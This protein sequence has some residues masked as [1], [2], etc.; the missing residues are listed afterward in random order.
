MNLRDFFRENLHAALAFSGGADS[1]YLL[2]AA[3][4]CGADVKPY[5]V[6][7]PFQPE[8]ELADARR[9]AEHLG[10][11]LTVLQCDIL[12]FPKVAENPTDRC[13]FCKQALFSLL[14]QRSRA[15]GYPVLIDGTN[16]SDDAGDRPGMRALKE[17]GVRSPLRECGLAKSEIRRRSKETGLFTWN[18]PSY[19]CLATRIP[20]GVTISDEM[21]RRVEHAES[22]LFR[23]GFAD[24]RVRVFC[25]AARIQLPAEQLERAVK[26]RK[27]IRTQLSSDFTTVLLDLEER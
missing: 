14:K 25:G 5:T 22:A 19:A 8:S 17:L 10:A 20:A 24:F 7:T 2:Y 12:S 23:L 11:S 18:K 1:S 13:Y 16:A 4:Q 15:D 6:K 3:L 21:L 27:E 9:M 26:L